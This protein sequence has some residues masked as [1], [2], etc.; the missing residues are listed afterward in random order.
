MKV[1]ENFGKDVKYKVPMG[2]NLLSFPKK[3]LKKLCNPAHIVF[4]KERENWEFLKELEKWSV[5]GE[6][7][8][9]FSQLFCLVEEQLGYPV[10]AQI[11]KTKIELG[12]HEESLYRFDHPGIQIS[13]KLKRSE[14]ESAVQGE[15][16]EIFNSLEKVFEQSGLSK[17]EVDL[18]RITGGSGQMPLVQERLC[19]L[20]GK[21]KIQMNEV[22][23]S[24]VQGLGKYAENLTE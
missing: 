8:K 1:S 16:E 17:D 20:F 23:Q 5:G 14:F 22:F 21:D 3:L 7:Q 11:E 15:L 24:V 9:F 6:D 2:N 13:M 4:L 10:Y 19:Q 18:V 12:K